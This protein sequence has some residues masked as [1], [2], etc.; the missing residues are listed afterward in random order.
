MNIEISSADYLVVFTYIIGVF[1]LAY[2]SS[3]SVSKSTNEETADSQYLA[4]KS[5][6][7]TESICSIIATEVSALTFVGIPAYAYTKDFTFIQIYF[8]AIWGRLI[9]GHV[10]LPRIYNKGIT[11]YGIMSSH[12]S[13][14]GGQRALSSIYMI[15][16]ILS[17]GVR[18]YSGS[19]LVAEFFSIN[20][21]IAVLIITIITFFYTLIG[22]LKAVVR[23]DIVQMGLFITGGLV[24]HYL[25]PDL[26]NGSWSEM[27]GNAWAAGK[28]RLIDMSSPGIFVA[29]VMG[30]FLFD[31]ATHGTDQD[32]IQRLIGNSSLAGGRR[33]IILSSFVSIFVGLVFLG[34]GSLLWNYYQVI[35]LPADIKPD[36]LF[37]HFITHYFPTGIKGLMVAGALAATM[38]TLDSSINALSS[39]LF[40]DI[41]PK[42]TGHKISTYYKIDTLIISLLMLSV[43]YLSSFSDSLLIL[44]LKI[45]SWTGGTLVAIFFSKLVWQKF[46]DF[47]LNAMNVYTCF[48]I[49]IIGVY[50]NTFIFE[51]TWF[52]NV[53][54]GCGFSLIYIFILSRFT[55]RT[56]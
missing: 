45:A 50:L 31:I 32:Y 2:F 44:G 38:S 21:Y 23:T 10:F 56:R 25:I 29:G 54:F 27:M 14:P 17:V 28:L 49:G 55:R 8:G 7:F 3:K 5:L 36:Y 12:N 20:I 13:T 39:C 40:S 1:T 46:I 41:I 52:W 51:N 42:R 34:V 19:I 30:G 16:K 18:L 15:A 26:I 4:N 6:T 37:A 53:Y 48:F 24:A 11:L 33:A 47:K 9:V 22:G 35:P 43:A